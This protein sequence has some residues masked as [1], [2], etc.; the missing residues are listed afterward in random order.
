MNAVDPTHDPRRRSIEIAGFAHG[1]Q[2][3]PAASRVGPLLMTGGVHGIDR[4]AGQIPDTIEAQAHNMFAN[5]EAILRAGGGTLDHGRED[6]RLP[7]DARSPRGRQRGLA[8]LLPGPREPAG[9]PY[10][11]LRNIAQID[12]RSMRRHCIHL[13]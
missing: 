12:A 5:L 3:I 7:S 1:D 4:A 13:R 2:P 8:H 10:A 6:H 9:A 11:R